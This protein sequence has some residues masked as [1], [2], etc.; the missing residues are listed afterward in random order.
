MQPSSPSAPHQPAQAVQQPDSPGVRVPPP[1]FFIAAFLV[2]DV[3]QSRLPLPFLAHPVALGL[4]GA[5]AVI[6][7]LFIMT[8]IPT[9]L[10][11]HGTLN[12]NGPSAQ[13]VT[14]GPYRFSRNP[15]YLGLTLLYAGLA[16][17]FANV[18]ALPLLIPLVLYTHVGVILPEERYLDR[19]FGDTYRVYKTRVRRWL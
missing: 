11:G 2:G 3:L 19:T 14:P 1:I 18:W 16:V 17:A 13:L 15:M 9:M 8:A 6:G 4:G 10:R 5:L 12:T 7:A